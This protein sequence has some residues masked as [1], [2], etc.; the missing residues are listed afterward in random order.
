MASNPFSRL[1]I[2]GKLILPFAII[3]LTSILFL[4]ATS[5]TTLKHSLYLSMDK[6][7]EITAKNL[8]NI[9][10]DPLAMGEYDRMQQILQNAKATDDDFVYGYLLAQDG[11]VIASTEAGAKDQQMTHDEFENSALRV[12]DYQRRDNPHMAGVFEI[13]L[14]IKSGV[15]TGPPGGVLRVGFSNRH[16]ESAVAS[17]AFWV[18]VIGVIA[19]VLGI[20][21][22]VVLI[23]RGIIKPITKVINL[24]VRVS[25]GD[26]G[27]TIQQVSE[28]EIGQLLKAMRD[29]VAYLREMATLAD[30]IAAGDLRVT[31]NP[32][33]ET[34]V[35]GN[36]F[37]KMIQSLH[38]I[39]HQLVQASQ[40]LS[41]TANELVATSTQQSAS[42]SEQASSIQQ[43]LATLDEIRAVVKQSS[44]KATSVVQIA[45]RS[46]DVSKAGQEALQ[47]SIE[48]M[49]KIR[50]QVDLIATNILELAEKTVQIAEITA[51]V[52]DIAE[53]SNLLSVNA[54]IEASKAGEAGRGFSVVATEVKNLASQ[55]KQATGQ[56]RA[57]LGEIQKATTTTV[58]VT[59]EGSKRVESGVSKV[60]EA[61]SNFNRLYDVIVES[62]QAARLIELATNQQVVGIEQIG[63]GMQ[64]LSQAA[65]QS[66]VGAK[67]QK[68][69]AQ[70]L[71]ELALNLNG[72]VKRYLLN[73]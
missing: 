53:Q 22:F 25:S 6:K 21:I 3:S 46:L 63:L 12:T 8:A 20:A 14:P 42:I 56:V 32:R 61:G 31:V 30:S 23:N 58:M 2:S 68:T 33:S 70:N 13:V 60:R 72:I 67:Q 7:A 55:S 52:N 10:A 36:A 62:S 18:I 57:I 73:D 28:D 51:S 65:H 34:D 40:S 5:I 49:E 59:E 54:A 47:H 41:A 48:A 35:F 69:T 64:N 11:R 39:I 26:L 43:A 71:S 16:L 1:G 9:L 44:D 17:S 45:E 4:G 15:G 50:D 19:L 66:V 24:A 27:Q 37:K 38:S 29:M